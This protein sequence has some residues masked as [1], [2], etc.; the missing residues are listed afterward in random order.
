MKKLFIMLVMFFI[1]NNAIANQNTEDLYR[2]S[3]VPI[4]CPSDGSWVWP[5][6]A[7][8]ANTIKFYGGFAN[9]NGNN[10]AY[11][12]WVIVWNPNVQS[13]PYSP[14]S[15]RLVIADDGPTNIYQIAQV[16]PPSGVASIT[17]IVSAVDVTQLFKTLV[18]QSI[19]KTVGH[20]S[21]GNTATG[22]LI[23]GSW[24]EVVWE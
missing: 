23:Y 16:M 13:Y 7:L 12:R 3:S 24:L 20:Q 22:P 5:G 21:V 9:Q 11:V 15:V 14:T 1:V 19:N 17:P 8:T 2:N 10:I 6:G 4:Y 18:S